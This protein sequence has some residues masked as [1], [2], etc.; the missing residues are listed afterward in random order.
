MFHI[1]NIYAEVTW[2][3]LLYKYGYNQSI[4]RF[5]KLIQCLLAAINIVFDGQ[6]IAKHLS[7]MQLLVEQTELTLVLDDLERID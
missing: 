4:Q 7:D 5:I 1:Q 2:K 6:N 3:Y